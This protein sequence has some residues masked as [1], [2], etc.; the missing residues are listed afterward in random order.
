VL[1]AVPDAVCD[2]HRASAARYAQVGFFVSGTMT[3]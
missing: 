1:I 2:E 3:R